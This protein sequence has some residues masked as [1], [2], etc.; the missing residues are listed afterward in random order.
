MKI[1]CLTATY[2]IFF[3]LKICFCVLLTDYIL[4]SLKFLDIFFENFKGFRIFYTK[5][6]SLNFF[7]MKPENIL[8]RFIIVLK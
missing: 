2:T 3:Q 4:T 1:I 7:F 6:L 8:C 5:I